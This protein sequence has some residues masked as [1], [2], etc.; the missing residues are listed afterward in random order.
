[1][2]GPLNAV[3]YQ[4]VVEVR[5]QLDVSVLLAA[6]LAMLQG[7]TGEADAWAAVDVLNDP[8]ARPIPA[9]SRIWD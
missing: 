3:R 4:M 6:V 5:A 9:A 8:T 2:T 7:S 1:M